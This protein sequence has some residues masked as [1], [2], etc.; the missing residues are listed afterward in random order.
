MTMNVWHHIR[1]AILAVSAAGILWVVLA[2]EEHHQ[3][4]PSAPAAQ[5]VQCGKDSDCKGDRI[6]DRG[7][8][9]SPR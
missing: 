9:V 5:S 2:C 3:A 4:Q 7:S 6:C 8:C 1:A